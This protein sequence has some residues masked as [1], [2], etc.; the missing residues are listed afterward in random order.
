[1]LAVQEAAA[2]LAYDDYWALSPQQRVAILKGLAELVLDV[3]AVRDHAQALAEAAL[4]PRL[5]I[6]V[7]AL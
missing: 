5:K 1:M 2:Q 7:D 4:M 6:A 3:E